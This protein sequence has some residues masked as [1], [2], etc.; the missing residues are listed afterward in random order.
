[1]QAAPGKIAD[2]PHVPPAPQVPLQNGTVA[3]SHAWLPS[4]TQPQ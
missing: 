1:M 3:L 4:G 2:G